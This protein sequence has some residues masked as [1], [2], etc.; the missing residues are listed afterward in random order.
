MNHNKIHKHSPTNSTR[1]IFERFGNT[2]M[3]SP[4]DTYE[5]LDSQKNNLGPKD[6]PI[7]QEKPIAK[8]KNDN[9]D[10]LE[11]PRLGP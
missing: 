1:K 7:E 4:V 5:E 11:P 2:Q 10:T 6:T 8:N 9:N 3:G